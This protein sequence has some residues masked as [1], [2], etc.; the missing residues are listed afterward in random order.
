MPIP[1]SSPPTRF[2]LE[3]EFVTL[4]A[5]PFYLAHLASAKHLQRPDFVA[6][7]KYLLRH[8]STP[9]YARYLT[10]PGP[11]LRAL[12][13]LQSEAFRR[14][15]LRPEVVDGLVAGLMEGAKRR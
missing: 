14:D 6:Y 12:E 1:P 11:T 4:L 9:E 8:W 13:L 10:H 15:V 2:E 3:L 7:L 5:S